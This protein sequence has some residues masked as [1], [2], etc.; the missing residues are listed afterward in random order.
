ME[1]YRSPI[2][3][4]AACLLV[5]LCAGIVYLWSVFRSPIAQAFEMTTQASGMVAS[6][7]L[8][9][10]V[11]GCLAGGI[12]NDKKG[13]RITVVIGVLLLAAGIGSSGLLTPAT[14]GLINLTYAV[15]GGVGSGFAYTACMSCVQKWLPEHRGFASGLAA[16]AFG[17][18][19][20]V[21]APLSRSLM[22]GYT[23]EMTGLVDFKAVFFTLAGIFFIVGIVASCFVCVPKP[24]SPQMRAAAQSGRMDSYYNE[25]ASMGQVLKTLAFWCLFFTIFFGVVAWTLCMPLI[26]DLGVKRGLSLN[27][28]TLTLSLAGV[29]NA[30]GRLILASLS[31]KIGRKA[32]VVLIALISMA[33]TLCMTFI[34]GY[35]YMVVVLLIAFAYGGVGPMAAA[36]GVDFFGT[37]NSARN[38]G[39]ITLSLGFSSILCNLISNYVL[40]GAEVPTFFMAMIL[41]AIPIF[42]MIV[43]HGCEK[44]L[45]A[46]GVK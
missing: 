17:F 22:S 28:A 21:F 27:Q 5:Q 18:S 31:D 46:R 6:Y 43:L 29:M 13:P 41:S 37:K 40:H 34:G 4:I 26:S 36:F 45:S 12:L 9:G 42:L 2:L 19:T 25:N 23:N 33:G 11:V 38:F 20:V 16:S 30:L 15:C 14:A 39:L 24:G 3:P 7:M 1:R 44:K 10:F 35:G 8:F 32:T